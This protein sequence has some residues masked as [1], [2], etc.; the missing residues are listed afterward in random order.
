MRKLV[1]ALLTL[2]SIAALVA[3]AGSAA[4]RTTAVTTDPAC[5]HDEHAFRCVKYLKNYDGD[6]ITFDIPGVHAL[7]GDKIS[8][9]VAHLDT[10][11]VKG[12]LPCEKAAARTAQRLIENLLKNAR[13]IDLVNVARDKY[14][15]ILADVQADGV[16]LKD[17]L[18]KNN[19]AY[20]YEGGTKRKTD[21]CK[22]GR[23]AGQ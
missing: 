12:K 11:E 1:F 16:D 4:E 13:R 2:G 6:T 7:L 20:A 3:G 5:A 18:L 19:L 17:T 22:I 9:R 14:F 15:R 21:W 8:V 23:S 10:P